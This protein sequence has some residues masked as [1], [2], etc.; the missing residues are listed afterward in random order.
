[1]RLSFLFCIEMCDSFVFVFVFN[2]YVRS[3]LYIVS[4]LELG[5]FDLFHFVLD[6]TLQ[7]C[8]IIFVVD[9]LGNLFA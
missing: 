4:Y 9:F 2:Q 8:S 6:L 5:F 1:M 3:Y 7:I